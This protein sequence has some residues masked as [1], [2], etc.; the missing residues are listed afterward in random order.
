MLLCGLKYFTC[1]GSSR[2]QKISITCLYC[3]VSVVVMLPAP[4]IGVGEYY[5]FVVRDVVYMNERIVFFSVDWSLPPGLEVK[6]TSI[7]KPKL[8]E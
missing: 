8:E 4:F 3:T 6:R 5:L 2:C 1:P 7:V